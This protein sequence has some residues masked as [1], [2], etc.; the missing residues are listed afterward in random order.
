M[1]SIPEETLNYVED[2]GVEDDKDDAYNNA[3]REEVYDA[4][5]EERDGD[6]DMS[7]TSQEKLGSGDRPGE[8]YAEKKKKR[9]VSISKRKWRW[10]VNVWS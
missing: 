2:Q 1:E 6:D 9:K 8:W 4:D 10:Y 3:I 5:D 7:A